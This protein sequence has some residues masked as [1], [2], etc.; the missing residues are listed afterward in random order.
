MTESSSHAVVLGAGMAG[1]LA[2]RVLAEFYDSVTVVERDRLPDHP[3]HRKGVPQGRHLHQFLSRGPQIIDEL[4]PGFIDEVATAGAVVVDDNPLARIYGRVGALELKH[5]GRPADPRALVLCQGSRPFME[6]HVRRRVAALPNVAILDGH[7]LVEPVTAAD[8]VTG[9]RISNRANGIATV[10][11]ADLVVDAMGKGTRTPTFLA[12][13]GFGS[14]PKKTTATEWAYSSQ[15]LRI[16]QGRLTERL[17]FINQGPEK[18]GGLMVAYEDDTWMLA[19]ARASHCGDPPADYPEMIA[20]AEQFFPQTIMSALRDATPLAKLSVYRNT[21]GRWW[22]Y[23]RM[24][25]FPAG[26]IVIGDALCNFNPLYGQGMTMAGV[27]ALALRD[28]LR[29]GSSRL[30]HRFFRAAARKI[31]PVW[32][33]NQTGDQALY[34]GPPTSLRQQFDNWTAQAALHAAAS[35]IAVVERFL[36][37]RNLIDPPSG[38]RDPALLSRIVLANLQRLPATPCSAQRWIVKNLEYVG[39]L[40]VPGLLGYPEEIAAQHRVDA[41]A[42]PAT[43]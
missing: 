16:P 17:V 22:R 12:D 29:A 23:D 36:R 32:E 13:H 2:A 24:P 8:A 1:L 3:A 31:R 26:L 11:Q 41:G 19:I 35:D 40:A 6:F 33:M 43:L 27:Q 7:E 28:C 21:A 14:P 10:L 39:R 25:R 5:T 4:L 42:A 34:A 20:A 37:V 30:P 38:L 15:L 18:P 9:V